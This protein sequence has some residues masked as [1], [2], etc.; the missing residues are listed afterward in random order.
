[1][2]MLFLEYSN[3]LRTVSMPVT[4]LERE[5]VAILVRFEPNGGT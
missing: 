4:I 1:M 3:W 5:K 2:E